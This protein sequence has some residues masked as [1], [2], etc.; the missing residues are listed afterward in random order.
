LLF[1][2]CLFVCVCFMSNLVWVCRPT[3][4]TLEGI[5]CPGRRQDWD[6]FSRE[7]GKKKKKRILERNAARCAI[8]NRR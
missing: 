3:R 2:L 4:R 5:K 6:W 8:D 7:N 1:L